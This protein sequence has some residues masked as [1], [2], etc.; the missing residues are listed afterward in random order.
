V[1]DVSNPTAPVVVGSVA[2]GTGPYSV[3]VAGRYAYT[4]NLNAAT[5]S[6]VD[7]SNPTAPVVVGSVAV[8]TGPHKRL[9]SRPLRLHGEQRCVDHLSG[10]RL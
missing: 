9:R 2:V 3:Y 6:V 1:V 8:G 4:A 7:V 5:I 10:R